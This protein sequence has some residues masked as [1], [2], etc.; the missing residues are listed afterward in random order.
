MLGFPICWGHDFIVLPVL[1]MTDWGFS[2]TLVVSMSAVHI[3]GIGHKEWAVMGN[4]GG[5]SN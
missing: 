3:V 5:E 1:W 4:A 2:G